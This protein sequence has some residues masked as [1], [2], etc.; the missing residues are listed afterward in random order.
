MTPHPPMRAVSQSSAGLPGYI[1]DCNQS[2]TTISSAPSTTPQVWSVGTDLG[3]NSGAGSWSAR[4]QAAGMAPGTNPNT[5]MTPESGSV[6]VMPKEDHEPVQNSVPKPTPAQED[7]LIVRNPADEK[8]WECLVCGHRSKKHLNA[9]RHVAE[10]HFPRWRCPICK[11]SF[12][13]K[14]TLRTH[15][16]R[17][18]HRDRVAQNQAGLAF[19]MYTVYRGRPTVHLQG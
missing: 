4:E 9:R 11:K 13:R 18:E 3:G 15:Y 19:D 16:M 2:E 7:A 10:S 6:T 17:K 14:Q 8:C 5:S 12:T 1:H